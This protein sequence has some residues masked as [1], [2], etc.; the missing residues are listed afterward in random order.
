MLVRLLKNNRSQGV[1]LIAVLLIAIG[2]GELSRFLQVDSANNTSIYIKLFGNISGIKSSAIIT[3]LILI[4]SSGLILLRLNTIHILLE[5]RSFMPLVFYLLLGATFPGAIVL[6]QYLIA[7]LFLIGSFSIL[8]NE[9]TN[10][11]TSYTV[12]N[13][14]LLLA[15]GSIFCSILIF[16][17]PFIWITAAIIKRLSW[18]EIIHPFI[19]FLLIGFF[20]LSYSILVNDNAWGFFQNFGKTLR[21][22]P[23]FLKANT[24]SYISMGYLIFIGSISSIYMIYK[25]QARKNYTRK[26]Y[27]V[28][29]IMFLYSLIVTLLFRGFNTQIMIIPAL[30]VAYLFSGYF[31]KKNGNWLLDIMLAGWI[32]LITLNYLYY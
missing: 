16:F 26:F 2:F 28:F 23:Q 24:L 8:T 30:P 18:R 14:S 7:G 32:I 31:N 17:I 20:I 5:N 22:E 13:A 27:Q 9:S 15:I 6:N 25:Q 4:L 3:G 10:S 11:K 21:I 1:V 29:L 19:A 12:F